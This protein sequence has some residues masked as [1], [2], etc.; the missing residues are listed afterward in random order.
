MIGQ[1]VEALIE[2]VE[3]IVPCYSQL[4]LS[5]TPYPFAVVSETITNKNR[6]K[7]LG[8]FIIDIWNN[9]LN[10]TYIDLDALAAKLYD[11]VVIKSKFFLY[12]SWEVI[13][14][15]TTQEE[16]L[17]RKQIRLEVYGWNTIQ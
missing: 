8:N 6:P 13:Q 5:E 1:I 16:G 2:E 12:G 4:P 17:S 3:S 10:D 14:N 11:I 7:F 9:K 15:V